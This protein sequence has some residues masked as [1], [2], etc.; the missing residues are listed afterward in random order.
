MP[1]I[2]GWSR[3]K[4]YHWT[5]GEKSK[6]KKQKNVFLSEGMPLYTEKSYFVE[7]RYPD[8]AQ[9]VLGDSEF[10]TIKEAERYAV[11]WMRRHPKG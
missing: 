11:N 7:L 6:W 8:G 10:P 4:R 1:K 9:I 3:V 2:K 5:L